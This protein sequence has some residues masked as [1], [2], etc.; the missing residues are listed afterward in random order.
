[1][2]D[3]GIIQGSKAQA[4][5]L[6]VNVDTVYVHTDIVK[7]DTDSFGEP[8]DNLYQYHEIQYGKDEYIELLSSQNKELGK[9]VD[10]ILGVTCNE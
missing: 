9:L 8:T 10:T 6:I 2:K 5:E 7:I 3:M 4:V 1:M